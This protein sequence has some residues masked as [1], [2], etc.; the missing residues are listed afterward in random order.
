[1]ALIGLGAVD[2]NLI[3]IIL[4][5]IFCLLNRF[6]NQL[7][8]KKLLENK[9]YT[10][11]VISFAESFIVIPYIIDRKRSKGRTL[12]NAINNIN[13][14]E[15]ENKFEYIYEEPRDIKDDVKYKE[16]YIILI[17]IIFFINYSM[18]IYTFPVK[19]NIWITYILFT[20][21]FYY[22]IF[23]AKLF[24]YHYLSIIIILLTGFIIDISQANFQKD[25]E[26]NEPE[27]EVGFIFSIVRVILLSFNYVIIKYT[28][29]K[30]YASPY[31]IGAYSGIIDLILFIIFALLDYKF[32]NLN[33]YNYDYFEDFDAKTI[34]YIL[35]LMA[36]NLGIFLC[37]LIIA[38]N[39]TPCHIFIMFIIGQ[40][41][42]FTQEIGDYIIVVIIGL[43]IMLFFSLVFTE[44]IELNFCGLSRNTKK[45]INYRANNEIIES[46]LLKSLT[47]EEDNDINPLKENANELQIISE[48]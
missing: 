44:I 39:N 15:E 12:I 40:I 35:G 28:I 34:F 23:K 31:E 19:S 3:A 20:S 11:I 45:N 5:C 48:D 21:I 27:R 32:F 4:S 46:N 42:Y 1:M 25:W 17:S 2:R 38:R 26:S 7:F 8:Q 24:N 36:T 6:I 43:I 22:L 13:S 37:C 33:P 30:K 18:F 29:E 41:A 47:I 14:N 9:V 16:L 10:N